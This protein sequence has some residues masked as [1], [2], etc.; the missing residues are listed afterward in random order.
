MSLYSPTQALYRGALQA[1]KNHQGSLKIQRAGLVLLLQWSEEDELRPLLITRGLCEHIPPIL[2]Q[3]FKDPNIVQ[4]VTALLRLVTLEEEGRVLC[5]RMDVS[6]RL[7]Q[8]MQYHVTQARI[9]TDGCAVLSN[10]AVDVKHKTVAIVSPVILDTV[11]LALLTQLAAV[12]CDLGDPADWTVIKSAC[13]TIKNFLYQKENLRELASRDDL[14]EGLEIIL[15]QGPR[16]SKDAVTVLEKLQLSRVQDESLQSQVLESLQFLWNKPVPEAIEEILQ[17]WQD[18]AWSARI[19][20]VSLHQIQDMLQSNHHTNP[21][22]LDRIMNGSKS[23]LGHPDKRVVKEVECLQA[24]LAG[25]SS[26]N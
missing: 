17:V 18:H 7:V 16:R 2:S 5:Q 8:G 26:S 9:Q 12:D 13:F 10:L 24:L 11:I 4:N 14:L 22:Q 1:M 3:H 6:Q 25:E 15:A 23:L 20:I 19:L 21:N